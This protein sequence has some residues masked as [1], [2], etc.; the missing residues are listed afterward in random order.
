LVPRNTSSAT[1]SRRRDSDLV[2]RESLGLA[3]QEVGTLWAS[4]RAKETRTMR[5]RHVTPFLLGRTMSAALLVGLAGAVAAGCGSRDD[6]SAASTPGT[7]AF[8]LKETKTAR[9][10][11]YDKPYFTER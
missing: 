5:R 8:L 10:E 1:S 9:W 6:S 7:V 2:A 4:L 11:R 3:L